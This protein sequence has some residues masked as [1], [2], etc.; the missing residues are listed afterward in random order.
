MEI[1][2]STTAAP[3]APASSGPASTGALI[4]SDFETF[5]K[6][7]TTQMQNQD[8]LEPMKSDELSVQLAT[9]SGVEQQVRTNDLLSQLGQQ[10]GTSGLSQF[11]GWVGMDA[12]TAAPGFFDGT[13]ITVVPQP[14]PAAD[15]AALIVRDAAGAE[16]E[17]FALPAVGTPLD[18]QGTGSDGNPLPAGVY[19]FEVESYSAGEVI[20]Q[21]VAEVY[22]RITEV[23]AEAGGTV[24]VLEGGAKVTADAVTA[25]RE[26]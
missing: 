2:P 6:M 15:S 24:L 21:T 16:V 11:A 14:D 23:R 13:P 18:W 19:T 12:R 20:S 5:L 8:P 4:D 3:A 9:F 22:S 26:G 25:L 1:T 7:L 17:R 10:L